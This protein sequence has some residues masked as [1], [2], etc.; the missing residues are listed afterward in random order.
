MF[1]KQPLMLPGN[2]HVSLLLQVQ[3]A[4]ERQQQRSCL[5][6]EVPLL[7]EDINCCQKFFCHCCNNT[8]TYRYLDDSTH[9][10]VPSHKCVCI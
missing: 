7:I 10:Q 9:L 8:N 5:Q 4:I 6:R 1:C 2:V 3:F